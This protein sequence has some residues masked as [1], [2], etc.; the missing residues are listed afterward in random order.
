MSTFTVAEMWENDT[1]SA[2]DL[3]ASIKA[4]F[5]RGLIDEETVG[6]IYIQAIMNKGVREGTLE[7]MG[8]GRV[9]ARLPS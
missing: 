2:A 1:L 8:G 5:D 9:R 7:D 4:A 3:M 6:S